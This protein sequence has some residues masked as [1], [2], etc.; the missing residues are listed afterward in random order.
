MKTVGNEYFYRIKGIAVPTGEA[1]DNLDSHIAKYLTVIERVTGLMTT[2][3]K[4]GLLDALKRNLTMCVNMLKNIYA[5]E[6]A[7]FAQQVLDDVNSGNS[8]QYKKSLPEL[9]S[10]LLA[11]GNEMLGERAAGDDVPSAPQS[12]PKK[13]LAVD[14]MPEMLASVQH[15]LNGQYKVFGVTSGQAA[16]KFVQGQKPDLFILDIDM[17]EMNGI[18]LAAALRLMPAFEKTPLVFLT[19][20]T[21]RESV[22][23]AK[24]LDAAAFVVKPINHAELLSKVNEFLG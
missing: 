5:G 6:L 17:P 15:A 14:D 2:N 10:Q 4:N 22:L 8:N 12:E 11:L 23:S 13:I 20:N 19:G 1:D 18:D 16:L 24:K 9:C 21:S 7:A 3:Q